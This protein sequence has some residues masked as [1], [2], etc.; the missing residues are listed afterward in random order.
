[1]LGRFFDGRVVVIN[2]KVR[3]GWLGALYHVNAKFGSKKH[4]HVELRVLAI[5]GE[6]YLS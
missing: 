1:L 2:E 4:S 3:K 6:W 5:L